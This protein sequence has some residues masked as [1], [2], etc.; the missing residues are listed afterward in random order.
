MTVLLAEERKKYHQALLDKGVLTVDSKGIPSN[1][2]SSSK[3]SISI[4]KGIA[5]RL[6]AETQ[7][8]AVGQTSGAKFEQINME[9]LAATF[10]KMQNIR[11]GKWHIVKLGN[12]NAI[13]ASSFVQYEHLDFLSRL[14][15]YN[16]QLAASMG[17]D[18]MVAPDVVVYREAVSDE[19]L[20]T[21]I[22]LVDDTVAKKAD[23]RAANGGLPILHASISAKWTMRSD[24]AQNSRTEALNLIRNRKGHL[25]HIVVVTGEPLPSR[26]ASLALGTGDIDCMY[27]FA[28]YELVE[29]VKATGAEDSIE[30]LNSLIDGKRLKDISDLPLDLCV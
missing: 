23:L 8:K 22:I 20:N 14:V 29:A 16:R 12:R 7:E 9:F 17:N 30:M 15:A 4:A 18:Y 21:P 1:A 26:L 28:L 3:L 10:P 24:R 25:P 6:M 13:K 27:H 11:P 19:E 2:D 5:E